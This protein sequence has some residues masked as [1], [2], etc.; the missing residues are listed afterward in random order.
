MAIMRGNR[1]RCHAGGLKSFKLKWHNEFANMDARYAYSMLAIYRT[2]S[3]NCNECQKK[4][5]KLKKEYGMEGVNI[6][7]CVSPEYKK[8]RKKKFGKC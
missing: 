2:A 1:G 6:T 8:A 3:E 7:D 5:K 4:I